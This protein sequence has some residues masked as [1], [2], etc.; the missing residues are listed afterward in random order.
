MKLNLRLQKTQKKWKKLKKWKKRI[1]KIW[2]TPRNNWKKQR[3]LRK[4][5]NKLL[6]ILINLTM[7]ESLRML[8]QKV[9]LKHKIEMRK[10]KRLKRK[11]NKRKSMKLNLVK[12]IYHGRLN[13]K[14]LRKKWQ[15]S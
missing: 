6:M 7:E 13:T 4:L 3:L 10:L 8:N 11:M 5:Q 2:T 1:K 9:K 15:K 12:I 14:I